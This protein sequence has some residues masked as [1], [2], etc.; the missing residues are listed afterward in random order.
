MIIMINNSYWI[1]VNPE[2]WLS[3][4]SCLVIFIVA[5]SHYWPLLFTCYCYSSGN[6]TSHLVSISAYLYVGSFDSVL[7]WSPTER[8]SLERIQQTILKGPTKL[9]TLSLLFFLVPF[10]PFFLDW[11]LDLTWLDSTFVPRFSISLD[12]KTN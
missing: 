2:S 11:T 7:T 1:D 5:R 12:A 8:S 4:I 9:C 3:Y 6:T 10:C